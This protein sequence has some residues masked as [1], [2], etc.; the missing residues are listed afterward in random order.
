MILTCV[1][2]NRA[3][4][5]TTNLSDLLQSSQLKWTSAAQEIDSC[6]TLIT[7]LKQNESITSIIDKAKVIG[8]KCAISLSITSPVDSIRLGFS[9]TENSEFDVFKFT[10]DFVVKVCDKISAEML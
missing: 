2:L 8:E 5:I 7:G 6:K 3:L 4:G 9:D 1:V 10:K